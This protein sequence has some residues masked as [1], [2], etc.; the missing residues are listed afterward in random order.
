MTL[1]HTDKHLNLI[2]TYVYDTRKA[3]DYVSKLVGLGDVVAE[4]AF[5]PNH[6][7]MASAALNGTIAKY[8]S[9]V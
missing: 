9:R 3:S 7:V 8:S 2:Q 6:P 4:V 1:F 5:N